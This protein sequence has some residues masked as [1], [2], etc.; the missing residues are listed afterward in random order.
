MAK[1]FFT[2]FLFNGQGHLLKKK[3]LLNNLKKAV[4]SLIYLYGSICQPNALI[5][6]SRPEGSIPNMLV[7]LYTMS[8]INT[9][10]PIKYYS[11][12]RKL[13]I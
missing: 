12:N 10:I 3:R 4:V 5:C 7:A 13:E 9:S 2:V 8:Q 1:I 11:K 6:L